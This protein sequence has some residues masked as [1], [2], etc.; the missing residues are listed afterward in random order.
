M[1]LVFRKQQIEKRKSERR[2]V[3][4]KI[5]RILTIE[6][7]LAALDRKKQQF[8]THPKNLEFFNTKYG[9]LRTALATLVRKLSPNE[10]R[11]LKNAR[12]E[13][14][15]RTNSVTIDGIEIDVGPLAG[16]TKS[17]RAFAFIPT[18]PV[19]GIKADKDGKIS[20]RK[21]RNARTKIRGK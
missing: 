17:G 20:V 10:K 11:R 8:E 7:Q 4:K 2:I 6:S 18:C 14:I 21:L 1:D 19:Y 13:R 15:G 5:G 16:V 9:E 12:K 3:T